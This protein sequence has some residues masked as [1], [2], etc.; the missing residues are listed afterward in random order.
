[1]PPGVPTLTEGGTSEA[2]SSALRLPFL[3]IGQ[4]N[5]RPG[6]RKAYRGVSLSVTMG[7]LRRR[8]PQDASCLRP[9]ARP[10]PWLFGKADVG[11]SAHLIAAAAS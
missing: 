8:D 1:M 7:A 2:L 10:G 4:R 3:R 11:A 6:D 5:Q 9:P